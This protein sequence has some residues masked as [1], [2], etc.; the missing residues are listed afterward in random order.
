MRRG[1]FAYLVVMLA[2]STSPAAADGA[3]IVDT[4]TGCKT[5]DNDA[6]PG[7]SVSWSGKCENGLAS[8]QGTAKYF[9]GGTLQAQY[10]GEYRNGK[11]DGHGVFTVL[12]SK[13]YRF[14]GR[15]SDDNA[16]GPGTVTFQN[17]PPISGNWSNGCLR[18]S[19]GIAS[20]AV[21]PESCRSQS[22]I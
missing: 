7:D 6:G 1:L 10:D 2:L 18:L 14:D 12:G 8:G 20:V 19:I 15:W 16:N 11:R 22:Q 3:W 21:T 13:G 17:G 9:G 4:H 5:W